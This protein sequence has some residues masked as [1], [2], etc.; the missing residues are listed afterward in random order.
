ME[1]IS[2]SK[3]EFDCPGCNKKYQ[4]EEAKI[5]TLFFCKSCGK[6]MV[7][8]HE[9][10]IRPKDIIITTGD[11]KEDYEIIGPV[12][13]QISNRGGGLFSGGSKYSRLLES[14]SSLIETQKSKGNLP[15]KNE[16]TGSNK[17][18][19]GYFGEFYQEPTQ[20]EISFFIACQELKKR[21]AAMKG[22]A[23]ISMRYDLDL[24]SNGFQY[25]YVQLYGT[26]VKLIV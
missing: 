13:F 15:N 8:P 5:G 1:T 19:S 9:S 4:S 12:F 23:I 18:F 10:N 14:Y 2:V 7:I 22:D 3:I 21:V 16:I 17:F 25:F 24:D 11:L 20:F 6:S 26:A